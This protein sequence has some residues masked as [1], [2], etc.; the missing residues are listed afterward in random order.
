M[1]LTP[2]ELRILNSYEAPSVEKVLWKYIIVSFVLLLL[3]LYSV[4]SYGRYY[5]GQYLIAHPDSPSAKQIIT[6]NCK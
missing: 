3:V 6:E 2:E 1:A 5:Q 4:F